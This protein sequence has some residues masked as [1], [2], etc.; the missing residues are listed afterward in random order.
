MRRRDSRTTQRSSSTDREPR[1]KVRDSDLRQAVHSHG[2]YPGSDLW[3]LL[4]EL[5]ER[6]DREGRN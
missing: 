1:M 5:Q 4:R 6:R 2:A 3:N